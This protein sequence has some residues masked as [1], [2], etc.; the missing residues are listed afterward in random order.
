MDTHRPDE[1][2]LIGSLLRI[3]ALAVSQHTFRE[4]VARYPDLRQAHLPV[5]IHIDHPPG[6]TRLTDLAERAQVTK[7]SMLELVDYLA[8]HG[9][10]E[11]IADPTDRRAKLVRLTPRGWAVHEAAS[12]IVTALQAEWGQR[13]GEEKLAELCRL[14]R[15]LSDTLQLAP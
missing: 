5:I 3:P 7:S 1:P 9:Y 14:L 8:Q 11:R 6:G 12:E 10:V 4:L 2:L 15:E 13:F